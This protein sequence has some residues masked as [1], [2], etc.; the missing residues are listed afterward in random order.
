MHDIDIQYFAVL[1]EQAGRSQERVA[2]SAATPADLY[3]ELRGRHNDITDIGSWRA[4][5]DSLA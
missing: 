3:D 2:T 5:R 1:R 4:Y